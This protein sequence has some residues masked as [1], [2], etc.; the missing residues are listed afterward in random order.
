MLKTILNKIITFSVKLIHPSLKQKHLKLKHDFYKTM[1]PGTGGLGAG[2][3]RFCRL[4][5]CF[6]LSCVTDG[7]QALPDENNAQENA[8]PVTPE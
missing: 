2:C 5:G 1:R 4:W 6:H 8:C 3:S 7:P